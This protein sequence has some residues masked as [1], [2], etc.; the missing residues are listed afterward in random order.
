MTAADGWTHIVP[1]YS[2]VKRSLAEHAELQAAN[3]DRVKESP[4][5]PI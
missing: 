1:T 4:C 2:R 3:I 5:A